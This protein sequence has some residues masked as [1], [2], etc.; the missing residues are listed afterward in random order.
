MPKVE[1]DCCYG[2]LARSNHMKAIRAFEMVDEF[3]AAAPKPD[4][5][6]VQKHGVDFSPL[7]EGHAQFGKL[8]V[9]HKNYAQEELQLRNYSYEPTDGIR[10]LAAKIKDSEHPG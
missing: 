9:I 1:H 6:H 3:M 10:M 7:L 5:A 8:G 4:N 2:M